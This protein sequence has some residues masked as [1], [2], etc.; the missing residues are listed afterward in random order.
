MPANDAV[1]STRLE[2]SAGYRRTP[3]IMAVS[4]EG[5]THSVYVVQRHFRLVRRGY[6]PVEVDRHLQVVSEWFR[7]SRAGE[8]ARELEKQLQGRESVIA[9]REEDAQ[10]LVES[11]R[12]EADATRSEEHTSELQ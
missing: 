2:E 11:K 8:K 1:V 7:Q 9:E 6:D 4:G 5:E 3:E 12:L 10:R